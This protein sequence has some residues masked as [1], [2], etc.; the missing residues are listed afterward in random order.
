METTNA[1]MTGMPGAAHLLRYLHELGLKFFQQP[2]GLEDDYRIMI[3][4]QEIVVSK[5]LESKT[6]QVTISIA[7]R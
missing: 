2:D 6:F 1:S 3:P 4:S 5:D 7:N